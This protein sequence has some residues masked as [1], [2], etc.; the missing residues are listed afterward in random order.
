MI[1][2]TNDGRPVHNNNEQHD[3]ANDVVGLNVD[4]DVDA[5]TD[6]NANDGYNDTDADVTSVRQV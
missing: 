2:N 1:V 3:T 5:D 4:A 6:A